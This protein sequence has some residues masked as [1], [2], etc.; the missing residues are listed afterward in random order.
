MPIQTPITDLGQRQLAFLVEASRLLSDSLDYEDTLATVVRLALPRFADWCSIH[1]IEPDNKVRLATLACS[2]PADEPLRDAFVHYANNVP[3]IPLTE[4]KFHD[5]VLTTGIAALIS[6]TDP[7]WA[8]CLAGESPYVTLLRQMGITS[9]II[10]PLV[11]RRRVLGTIS[12]MAST[13]GRTYTPADRELAEELARRA[14]VA[15]DNARLYTTTRRR[16]AE[17]SML[18]EVGRIINA[19]LDFNGIFDTILHYIRRAF[20]YEML[21][22]YLCEENQIILK[23][24]S[25]YQNPIPTFA[26]LEGVIGSVVQQGK[27]LFIPDVQNHPNYDGEEPKVTQ[28]ILV[29]LLGG[30]NQVLGVLTLEST[31]VPLLSN[32]DLALMSLLAD[33]VSVALTN[34]RLFSELQASERRYR[35]LVNQAAD[36]IIVLNQTCAIVEVN[37]RAT[38]LLGYPREELLRVGFYDLIY[39]E[40][41]ATSHRIVE[42]L[43]QEGQANGVLRLQCSDGEIVPTEL[44]LGVA[45]EDLI[46]AIVRDISERRQLEAQLLQSQ[47]LEAV[48]TLANGIAHDFN[49]LLAAISGAAALVLEITPDDDTRRSDLEEIARASQ[50]GAGLTRQLLAFSRPSVTERRLLNIADTLRDAVRMLR[51]MI[52][53]SIAIEMQVEPH[54]WAILADGIQIQQVIVNLVINARDAMPFG[55]TVTIHAS[56]IMLD[57]AFSRRFLELTPGPHLRLSVKDTG[58]GMDEPTRTRIFEPF[59]TTRRSGSGTGL[60]LAIT[61]SIVRNHGGIIEVESVLGQGTEV[62]I[63]LPAQMTNS[64]SAD[65][66]TPELPRGNGELLLVVDDEPEIRRISQRILERHGYRVL[67]AEDGWSAMVLYRAHQDEMSAVILDLTMPVMDGKKT[68]QSLRAINPHLPVVFFSGQSSADVAIHLASPGTAFVAKP[69]SSFDLLQSVERLLQVYNARIAE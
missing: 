66:P 56:N 58:V 38:L 49:N 14:G 20:G 46:L 29:P 39:S 34:A 60:G 33:Q 69:F 57:D 54:G 45:G 22:L 32:D 21:S 4:F 3:S 23:A 37:D 7:A 19:S 9:T 35:T 65:K 47:K 25:G 55:G 10:V 2:N 50:R 6:P 26:N 59:F 64:L 17:L 1:L 15:I 63:Y 68:F 52:P 31:G 48:G 51:S 42:R 36:T 16:L 12:F 18:Q 11:S 8:A 30:G 53:S 27:P 44:S 43:S 61:Q 24:S 67:T 40:D 62:L 28:S 41:L 5:T 13:S